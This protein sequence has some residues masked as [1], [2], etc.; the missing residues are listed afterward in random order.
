MGWEVEGRLWLIHVDI[1]QKPTQY[2]KAIIIQLKINKKNT[3]CK[4]KNKQKNGLQAFTSISPS[5]M[6]YLNSA[7]FNLVTLL[8]SGSSCTCVLL[9]CRRPSLTSLLGLQPSFPHTPLHLPALTSPW[10]CHHL[11]LSTV[12]LVIASPLP[13]GCVL[14]E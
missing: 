12:R 2:C 8:S 3:F 4:E 9:S 13:L 5:A 1:Q 11:T 14:G 6:S 10:R 7:P